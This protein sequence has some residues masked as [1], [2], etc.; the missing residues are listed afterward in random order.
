VVERVP[1]KNEVHGSIPCA[2][3]LLIFL[4]T[5]CVHYVQYVHMAKEEKV[6]FTAFRSDLAFYL[7]KLSKGEELHIV[8]ARRNKLIVSLVS[9]KGKWV[10]KT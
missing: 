6:A 2:P 5:Y 3:T 8:N 4:L 7:E 9:A 10:K 1:D